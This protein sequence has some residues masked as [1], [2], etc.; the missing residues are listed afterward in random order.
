MLQLHATEARPSH[1]RHAIGNPREELILPLVERLEMEKGSGVS[2]GRVACALFD[3]ST[4]SGPV[5]ELAGE[6]LVS[7]PFGYHAALHRALDGLATSGYLQQEH[8]RYSI[9][10]SGFA[11]T[12]EPGGCYQME[13]FFPDA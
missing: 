10:S 7:H 6:W 11:A 3:L 8:D 5:G 1:W 2:V 9:T 4:E 12:C 13:R